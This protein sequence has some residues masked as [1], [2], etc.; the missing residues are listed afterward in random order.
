MECL[1]F[2]RRMEALAF[3]KAKLWSGWSF[4]WALDSKHTIMTYAVW[5]CYICINMRDDDMHALHD[6]EKPIWDK[7]SKEE[8]WGENLTT[9]GKAPGHAERTL[10]CSSM[11]VRWCKRGNIRSI[12]EMKY[13]YHDD[14]IN[15]PFLATLW[16]WYMQ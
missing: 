16:Q 7:W 9:L 14:D 5:I 8:E 3:K 1:A 2:V 13:I 6:W 15:L 12:R 10:G 4:R 11:K